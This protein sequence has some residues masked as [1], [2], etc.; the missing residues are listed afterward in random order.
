MNNMF[1]HREKFDWRVIDMKL[2]IIIPNH[3]H[4]DKVI[5]LLENLAVYQLPCIMVDDASNQHTQQI[6]NKLAHKYQW[7]R[8]ITL[9]KNLGK[10]GA[11]IAGFKHAWQQQFT[12]ALQIDADGQHNCKDI[13]LFIKASELE[14]NAMIVGNPQYDHTAPK[15]RLYGRRITQFWVCIET[16]SLSMPDAMCGFRIYPLATTH[17]LLSKHT[18]GE[19]MDF[20][21]EI[22]VRLYW[23][24]CKPVSIPTNVIYPEDGSSNFHLWKDNLK[25]SWMHTKLCFGLIPRLPMLLWRK[26]RPENKAT[27]Y[28]FQAQ[29]AGTIWGLKFILLAYRLIGRRITGWLLYPIVSY[30]YCCVGKSRRASNQY[31]Q[32]LKNVSTSVGIEKLSSFK[33]F[34]TFSSSA[35]DK[36]SVWNNDITIQQIDFPNAEALHE[37]GR[38]KKGAVILT[39]HLGNIEI[40]RA[41]SR[42]E[43]SVKIN[44]F[45]FSKNAVNFN[46]ILEKINPECKLNVIEVSETDIHL[47]MLLKQKID[48]GEFVVIVADRVST[49]QPERCT[50]ANFLGKP[51][52]FP[53]G[54]FI[55]AG[56]MHCPVYFMLCIPVENKF[57][58][59]FQPFADSIALQRKNRQAELTT[60]TQKYADLLSYYC[61]EHPLQW[62]NFFDFWAQTNR[63]MKHD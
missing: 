44:A 53:Q 51:A 21:I 24:S 4:G 19:R 56:L 39:A 10:G 58:V 43:P 33:H 50:I 55:L 54:P 28:W 14:P 46:K 17:K 47:A 12:H 52:Q 1:F 59:I 5:E 2:C 6:L 7:L 48:D 30:F 34:L 16:L 9:P 35:L 57:K 23:A 26:C 45:V 49:T 20:D 38:M 42:F 32:Q 62:F 22:I 63:E 13:P 11:V 36:L 15:S 8:L 37:L 31:I 18:L 29:E 41:L 27:H 25:I 3:N 61:Q 60:Y 40:A